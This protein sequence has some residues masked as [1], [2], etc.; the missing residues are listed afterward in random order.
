MASTSSPSLKLE[1]ITTGEQTGTWGDTTNV[2]LGTLLEQAIT[3]YIAIAKSDATD[4]TLSNTAYVS[5]ENRN[6]VIEFT[7]TPGGA[8]NVIVPNAEKLWVFKNS[9]NGAMTIKTSG[10]TT[11]VTAPTS[12]SRWV[13]CDGAGAIYDTLTGTLAT[14]S[15]SS[16]AITG[17]T[18]TGLTSLTLASGV[19]SP[20]TNDAAAL[21][22]SSLGW[23]DLYLATG[24]FIDWANNDARITHSTNT[25]AFSGAS[26]GYTFDAFISPAA[27][28]GAALGSSTSAWSDAYLASGGFIDFANNDV[29]ITHSTNTLAFTG[30]SSGYTFDVPIDLA[31]GGT[32]ASLTDPN[33]NRIL[34]WNDSVNQMTWLATGNGLAITGN[35]ID[36][37]LTS[38]FTAIVSGAA[39]NTQTF[40]ATG[41]WTK[42]NTGNYAIIYA[43]G[44]GGGGEAT[45]SRNKSGGGGGAFTA[46]VID[47]SSLSA[48]VTATV[49]A[50]GGTGNPGGSSTFGTYA[51]AYGGGGGS[52]SNA[53]V[54]LVS[55]GGGGGV[56]GAG[57]NGAI[58]TNLVLG[59]SG[60]LSAYMKLGNPV[61][62][63]SDLPTASSTIS[64]FSYLYSTVGTGGGYGGS[65]NTNAPP[66]NAVYGGG[67]GAG[68]VSNNT[69][70]SNGANSVWGGGGGGSVTE[71]GLTNNAGTSTYGGAGAKGNVNTSA[72]GAQPGGGGGG[73]DSNA[74]LLPT[75]GAGKIIVYVY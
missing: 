24:G 25:L 13:Y 10:G 31:S 6:M 73:I 53:N 28:D 75:G 12:S 15:A 9:T 26:L 56:S 44:G 36:A 18:I 38:P 27:N 55:G 41:T 42:P 45:G 47:L 2:N 51:T 3:G 66:G 33:A 58:A 72:V 43:W 68:C 20:A 60:D 11:T 50:G 54:T 5:N 4:Y 22:S 48:T 62:T 1:L 46:S 69:R 8:F 32:G 19:A 40:N 37:T 57:A 52:L 29:R 34:F 17:G 67:G 7:G 39:S 49:A 23:S 64:G 71:N 59:G 30:A 21:G 70:N 65:D 63:A 35:T 16:V 14:Q 74:A 61:Y